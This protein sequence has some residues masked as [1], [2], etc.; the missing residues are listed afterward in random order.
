MVLV[1]YDYG[2]S[3]NGAHSA[4]LGVPEARVEAVDLDVRFVCR[5]ARV[6]KSRLSCGV[7]PVRDFATGQVLTIDRDERS[8]QL[9]RTTSP[10]AAST[11]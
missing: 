9:N 8:I 4:R 2:D 6:A 3:Q 7:I 5:D 1:L 11:L 10:R